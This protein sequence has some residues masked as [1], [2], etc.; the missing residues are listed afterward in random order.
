MDGFACSKKPFWLQRTVDRDWHKHHFPWGGG[1]RRMAHQKS[2]SS[3]P[4]TA[5][6]CA[7]RA[8][9]STCNHPIGWTEKPV[10]ILTWKTIQSFP[11]RLSGSSPA[12]AEPLLFLP[13]PVPW[14]DPSK[15]FYGYLWKCLS[16]SEGARQPLTVVQQSLSIPPPHSGNSDVFGFIPSPTQ[17]ATCSWS[18]QDRR[19]Y[20]LQLNL[21]SAGITAR[22]S[23]YQRK[24]LRNQ[25]VCWLGGSHC[26]S[27][28]RL[29]DSAHTGW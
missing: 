13:R 7:P 3:K 22:Y 8:S 4:R 25:E 15:N 26:P 14:F 28:L 19:L 10:T 27:L 20:C 12:T 9:Q 1:E 23:R 16:S 24:V 11:S 2:C 6:F 18:A 29:L 17:T 21:L 5:G